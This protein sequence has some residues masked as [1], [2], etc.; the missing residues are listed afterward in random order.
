MSHR[1]IVVVLFWTLTCCPDGFAQTGLEAK[2]RESLHRIFGDSV[3]VASRVVRFSAEERRRIS[4][5]LKSAFLAESLKVY[6]C[7]ARDG[8]ATGYGVVD[9]VKGKTQFITYLVAIDPGGTVD[10]VDVLYYREGYGGEIA[11]ESFRKQFRGKS[12]RDQLRPGK[13]IKNISGATISVHAITDGVRKILK[14]FEII[15]SRVH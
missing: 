4:D 14:A 2:V 1:V 13:D 5:S 11:F 15:H 12:D 6:E 10:D 8:R 9:N 3:E 7:R